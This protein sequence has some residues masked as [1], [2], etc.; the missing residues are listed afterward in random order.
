MSS[1]IGRRSEVDKVLF[2]SI[3]A[4]TNATAPLLEATNKMAETLSKS[5]GIEIRVDPVTVEIVH[6]GGEGIRSLLNLEMDKLRSDIERVFRENLSTNIELGSAE[7]KE[8]ATPM[9]DV[10]AGSTF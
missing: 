3:A 1:N 5:L 9:P 4:L 10:P 8:T 6:K 2:D 7:K